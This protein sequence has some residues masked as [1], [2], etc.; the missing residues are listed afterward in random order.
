MT[1]KSYWPASCDG[2]A[3]AVTAEDRQRPL[4][5]ITP[6]AT[7]ATLG[8]GDG[9]QEM[10]H[11]AETIFGEKFD[12]ASLITESRMDFAQWQQL[13]PAG[14]G[15]PRSIE[16]LSAYISET[17]QAVEANQSEE[18]ILGTV[19]DALFEQP[20]EQHADV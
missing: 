18:A 17:N 11:F 14:A 7:S 15:K 4:G 5:I 20:P 13:S 1:L 6:V 19:L 3:D 12:Q 10:L 2:G 9:G 16:E 8:G